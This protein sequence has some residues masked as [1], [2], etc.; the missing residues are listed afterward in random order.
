MFQKTNPA[1][2]SRKDKGVQNQYRSRPLQ[3][4]SKF[5]YVQDRSFTKTA[6]NYRKCEQRVSNK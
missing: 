2:S 5:S 1:H 6:I 3:A 4:S